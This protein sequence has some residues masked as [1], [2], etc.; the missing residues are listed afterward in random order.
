MEYENAMLNRL[1]L[2]AMLNVSLLNTTLGTNFCRWFEESG[3][4]LGYEREA[5]LE[6]SRLTGTNFIACVS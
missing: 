2:D 3:S 5:R 1:S 4:E 6:A